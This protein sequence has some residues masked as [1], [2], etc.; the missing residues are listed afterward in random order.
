MSSDGQFS[1]QADLI[2]TDHSWNAPL[3]PSEP[4]RI[5]L[6]E[7]VYAL[8]EIKTA[9]SPSEV[10]DA[11]GKCRKF[12]NLRRH[13][14]DA[15]TRPRLSDSLFVLWS[16]ESPSA[17]TL[18]TTLTESLKD[19]PV[20]ERPDFVVVPGKLV[21]T[22]GSYRELAA[23]G[24][25]GSALRQELEHTY[26][27]T[28]ETAPFERIQINESGLDSLFLWWVWVLSWLKRAGPRN[29]ELLAYLPP[30]KSWGRIV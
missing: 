24:Q 11:V 13:Y 25:P 28:L 3:Y 5:W 18:K 23:L 6:V 20:T 21:A 10:A 8:F 27:Q 12:K 17:E 26:G 7:A 30:N 16:Y 4:N 1:N 22:S 15:P 29:S 19:V 9:L 2:I 14:S